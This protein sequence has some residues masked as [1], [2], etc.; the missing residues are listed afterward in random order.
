M[1]KNS[2]IKIKF[3]SQKLSSK[4]ERG[5][6]KRNKN[7]VNQSPTLFT[8]NLSIQNTKADYLKELL[9]CDYKYILTYRQTDSYNES[10]SNI[11]YE[12]IFNLAEDKDLIRFANEKES[13]AMCFSNNIENSILNIS[14]ITLSTKDFSFI[15]DQTMLSALKAG[16]SVSVFCEIS[17]IPKN[18][19]G[20]FQEHS[21]TYIINEC[22]TDQ[23]V[24]ISKSAY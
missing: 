1:N 13:F 24:P 11:H 3:F 5:N 6:I 20:S 21:I 14:S 17:D 12:P 9:E 4:I 10:T 8:Y 15:T 2:Q 22:I 23:I 16:K 7:L 18:Y 19:S